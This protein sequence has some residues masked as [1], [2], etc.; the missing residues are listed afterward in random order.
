MS[1]G[2]IVISSR[3]EGPVVNAINWSFTIV[4]AFTVAMKVFDK[5]QRTHGLAADDYLLGAAFVSLFNTISSVS[6]QDF[7]R[8]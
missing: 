1:S 5:W 6:G 3:N 8:D 4:V 2:R 7:D